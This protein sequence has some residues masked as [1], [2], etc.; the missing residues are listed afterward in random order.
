M[1]AAGAGCFR[2]EVGSCAAGARFNGGRGPIGWEEATEGDG[3]AALPGC[4]MRR[5]CAAEGFEGGGEFLA[6]AGEE[7]SLLVNDEEA[8]VAV[9]H[10]AEWTLLE[11]ES[12][13]GGAD[14]AAGGDVFRCFGE[15]RQE[16]VAD[17]A[18]VETFR[19]VG[20]EAEIVADGEDATLDAGETTGEV[21][22]VLQGE[23]FVGVENGA[24]RRRR[25]KRVTGGGGGD[26]DV[27]EW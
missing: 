22:D 18:D 5:R 1:R 21:G 25:T 8:G 20:G 6:E 14:G 13:G 16:P 27:R 3:S 12:E 10:D 4:W 9:A 26:E 23:V 2:S 17:L 19:D 15:E 11:V 7:A 24:E